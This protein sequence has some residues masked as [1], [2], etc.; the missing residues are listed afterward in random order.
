M[1][2]SRLFGKRRR[3]PDP[4]PAI[5]AEAAYDAARTD[6]ALL[7]DTRAAESCADERPALARAAARSDPDFIDIVL[8]LA[9]R[10]KTA[11][12][13]VL[14]D[15]GPAADETAAK[16]KSVGFEDVKVVD[17]GISA[18]REA[19]LPFATARDREA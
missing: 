1:L 17:G 9:E 11:P 5:S 14:S 13:I 4:A 12:L 16:L 3:R 6:A 2:Y 15:D 10:K 8:A 7:L 18:W 19:G